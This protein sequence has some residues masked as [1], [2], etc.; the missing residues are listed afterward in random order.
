MGGG[1]RVEGW[2]EKT[3]W[4]GVVRDTTFKGEQENVSSP[5][6][7][8]PRQYSLFLLLEVRLREGKALESSKIILQDVDFVMSRAKKLSRGI[9]AHDRKGC[10]R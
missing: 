1:R 3:K 9:T 4:G 5:G 10:I 6:L 8:V 2:R 7:K